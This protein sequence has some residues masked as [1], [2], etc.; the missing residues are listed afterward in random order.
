MVTFSSIGDATIAVWRDS[1]IAGFLSAHPT[2]PLIGSGNAL[3]NN[4]HTL[5][6]C[7]FPPLLTM[8][9][10]NTH[11]QSYANAQV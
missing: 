3:G 11:T 2:R 10:S 1:K 8:D 7:F 5:T 9:E 4:K 6:F